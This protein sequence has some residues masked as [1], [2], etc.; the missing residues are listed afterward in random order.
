MMVW[1]VAIQRRVA[2]G[3][4]QLRLRA[5]R[6][7]DQPTTWTAGMKLVRLTLRRASV[8]AAHL[9]AQ[10][11]TS[12]AE[13]KA[14][15]SSV[16]FTSGLVLAL[17]RFLFSSVGSSLTDPCCPS[18]DCPSHHRCSLRRRYRYSLLLSSAFSHRT[19]FETA[20]CLRTTMPRRALRHSISHPVGIGPIRR[21]TI[22][23]FPVRGWTA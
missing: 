3:R 12:A 2:I 11:P 13:A 21:S 5:C 22:S 19:N 14:D 18:P 1:L 23:A 8:R 16:Q 7:S 4:C 17:N 15:R 6:Q 9:P 10:P 20:I